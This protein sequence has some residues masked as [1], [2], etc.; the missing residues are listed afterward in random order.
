MG[1]YVYFISQ[2]YIY[3]AC[4]GKLAA[5]TVT[6]I[7]NT[8][9]WSYFWWKFFLKLSQQLKDCLIRNK[10]TAKIDSRFTSHQTK[11]IVDLSFKVIVHQEK[12]AYKH[13]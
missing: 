5:A 11:L 7:L 1:F 4:C 12:S 8:C 10:S 9:E 13:N 6:A 2:M 3:L